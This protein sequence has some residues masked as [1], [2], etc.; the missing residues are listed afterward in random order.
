MNKTLTRL[1]V[2]PAAAAALL[3]GTS[4]SAQAVTGCDVLNLYYSDSYVN[5]YKAPNVGI[6]LVGSRSS[7]DYAA[8]GYSGHVQSFMIPSGYKARSQYSG[9]AFPYVGGR[10]YYMSQNNLYLHIETVRL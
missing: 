10:L 3:V 9:A 5:V 7:R 6:K 2:A 1:L 4:V 8:Y